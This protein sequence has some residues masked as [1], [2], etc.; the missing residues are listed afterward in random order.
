MQKTFFI[1]GCQRSGTT[2][3]RLILECHG[4]IQCFDEHLGYRLLRR[5]DW[6]AEITADLVGFKAPMLTE[7]F[8]DAVFQD[9]NLEPFPNRHA[10]QPL[11]FMIRDVRDTVASMVNYRVGRSST[12]LDRWG[13]PALA[14]K[15]EHYPEYASQLEPILRRW[16]SSSHAR[17]SQGALCWRYKTNA[18]ARYQALGLPVLV[19]RYEDVVTRPRTELERVCAFL[20]VDWEEGL[21]QHASRTHGEVFS[22]GR[23]IGLTDPSRP[24][25]A[26]SVRRWTQFSDEELEVILDAAGPTQAQFYER[27]TTT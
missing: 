17:L 7:Q 21:L 22:N 23:T 5:D 15:M 10:G 26:T 19:L 9:Y 24:I 1:V 8:S 18:L 25:D 3:L 16:A 20:G 4:R 13:I 2:L 14:W 6:A 12:W 11:I 27:I